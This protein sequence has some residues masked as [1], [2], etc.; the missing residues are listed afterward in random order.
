MVD[1]SNYPLIMSKDAAAAPAGR[2]AL[3]AGLSARPH[4]TELK[5]IW[6]CR[7][8]VPGDGLPAAVSHRPLAAVELFS[9]L[10]GEKFAGTA[11]G[12]HYA[13]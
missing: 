11:I 10:M 13:G 6:L 3:A 4:L 12:E 9:R 8:W 5:S 2:F 1:I 7:S